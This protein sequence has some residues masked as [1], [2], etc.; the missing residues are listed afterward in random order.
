MN[1]NDLSHIPYSELSKELE[2]GGKFVCYTYTISVI[3][4][5]FRR[6]SQ[7]YFLK[8]NEWGIK[9]GWKY[10]LISLLLGL[11]GIPWGSVYTLQAIWYS[12]FPIEV[13]PN[14][15]DLPYNVY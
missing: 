2:K 7:V 1:L 14:D 4:M 8:S 15:T 6:P 11:W 3:F 9:Y 5:T 10:L 13:N 12:F